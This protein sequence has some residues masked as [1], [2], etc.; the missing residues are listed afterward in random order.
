MKHD[1]GHSAGVCR[2]CP[3]WGDTCDRCDR[4]LWFRVWWARTSYEYEEGDYL[5]APCYRR[6]T[7]QLSIWQRIAD[8]WRGRHCRAGRHAWVNERALTGGSI[9]AHCYEFCATPQGADE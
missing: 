8:W 7:D 2:F 3:D 5:C 6:A 4:R 1:F 9:C